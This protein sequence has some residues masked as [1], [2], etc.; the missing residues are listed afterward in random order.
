MFEIRN[1]NQNGIFHVKLNRSLS[2]RE[3]MEIA[4]IASNV[5]GEIKSS[6]PM[7]DAIGE[8]VSQGNPNLQTKLGEKPTT[9]LKLGDYKEP[10]VGV[11]IK[12]LHFPNEHRVDVI[13]AFRECTGITLIGSRD[14]VYGNV[15]CPVLK[16]EIADAIIARFKILG[17]YASIVEGQC[18]RELEG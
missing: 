11:R 13:K 17:M 9:D 16:R 10:D 2:S 7:I 8:F 14:I 15:E 6:T 18:K 1:E 12:M 4:Q 3:I 5:V